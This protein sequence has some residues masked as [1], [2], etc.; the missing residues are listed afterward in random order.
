MTIPNKCGTIPK[1]RGHKRQ[2]RKGEWNADAWWRREKIEG[3]ATAR[4]GRPWGL[5]SCICHNL[6]WLHNRIPARR[7]HPCQQVTYFFYSTYSLFLSDRARRSSSYCRDFV[8]TN[9]RR[10]FDPLSRP[11]PPTPALGDAWDTSPVGRS[12]IILPRT[13]ERSESLQ[14]F[15]TKEGAPVDD[16]RAVKFLIRRENGGQMRRCAN[17]LFVLFHS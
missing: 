12:A 15:K 7:D 5:D 10:L 14:S 1:K 11:S 9:S 6:I 8:A 13:L 17:G 2:T 4:E 3:G 16:R